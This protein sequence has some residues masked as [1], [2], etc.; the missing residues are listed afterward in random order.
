MRGAQQATSG[1]QAAPTPAR[2]PTSR[3]RRSARR[4]CTG[5][6]STAARRRPRPPRRERRC[7]RHQLVPPVGAAVLH[8]GATP[9]SPRSSAAGADPL[10]EDLIYGSASTSP[11]T[12]PRNHAKMPASPPPPAAP[13]TPPPPPPPPPPMPRCR[14]ARRRA[15]A[16][17]PPPPRRRP[18][19]P[20]RRRPPSWRRRRHPRS[21]E[22]VRHALDWLAALCEH[23]DSLRDATARALL[24]PSVLPLLLCL[25]RSCD[26]SRAEIGMTQPLSV[27]DDLC[28]PLLMLHSFKCAL[29]ERTLCLYPALIGLC[30]AAE[31]VPT[32]PPSPSGTPAGRPA[33][34]PAPSSRPTAP[35]TAGRSRL[36]RGCRVEPSIGVNQSW[37]PSWPAPAP[38]RSGSRPSSMFS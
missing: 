30:A 38:P 21:C 13:P 20:R 18:P 8:L 3:T 32:R 27:L 23:G 7:R 31:P 22:M 10:H 19:P 36:R 35:P 12:K 9:R 29:A 37:P 11:N 25:R 15:A 28:Y 26:S 34:P 14:R 4:R 2:R 24:R 5:R 6:A 16:A 17:P 33:R 1:A